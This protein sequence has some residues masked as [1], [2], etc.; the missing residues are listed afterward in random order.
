MTNQ[1]ASAAFC[2]QCGAAHPVTAA[3][4]SVC[5]ASTALPNAVTA[6]SAPLQPTMSIRPKLGV[7]SRFRLVI[8][9]SAAVVIAL[10]CWAASYHL[11]S[12]G[13]LQ[14]V[15]AARDATGGSVAAYTFDPNGNFTYAV[16]GGTPQ[17]GWY[18]ITGDNLD[19]HYY[20]ATASGRLP[21]LPHGG[22]YKL[23]TGHRSF[24]A[25]LAYTRG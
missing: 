8:L 9:I 12:T 19:L 5:G 15:Y 2:S 25:G 22:T 1:S 21:Y 17:R 16:S 20:P 14:G 13:G 4:C 11:L 23:S 3:F 24:R 6:G 10:L 7:F 18:S